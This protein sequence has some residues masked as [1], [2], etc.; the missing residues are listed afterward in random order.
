MLL[1]EFIG[2]VIV[3][4]QI[5]NGSHTMAN[6]GYGL[7]YASHLYDVIATPIYINRYNNKLK[8]KYKLSISP[9]YNPQ[10]NGVGVGFTINF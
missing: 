6:I 7:F 10:D 5:E 9:T 1:A 2:A 3:V 8:Q 4:A